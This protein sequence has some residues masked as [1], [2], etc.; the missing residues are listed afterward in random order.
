M[1]TSH[2]TWSSL[3][4]C[5]CRADV[6]RFARKN[7]QIEGPSEPMTAAPPPVLPSTVAAGNTRNVMA[8]R[9]SGFTLIELLLVMVILA[10]L[11][12]LIIPMFVGR[13]EQARVTAA[14]TDIS[15]ISS[16][17]D[18]FEIDNGRYPT[19]SEG[20]M[21]LIRRPPGM[22]N[23]HGPYLKGNSVPTDPW[24]HPYQYRC[25]G[26]HSKDGYDLWSLG[27]TGQEGGPGEITNWGPSQ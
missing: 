22:T 15:N 7:R 4:G 27:P 12:S 9:S 11:A 5:G 10:I 13:A 2:L 17:L 19:T 3:S 8:S 24:G 14:Q 26:Q 16:A 1:S 21:A 25:P 6:P 23:W 18:T 20:L